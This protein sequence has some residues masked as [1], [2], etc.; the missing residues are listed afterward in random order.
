MK[1]LMLITALVIAA[2]FAYAESEM[3]R[4][5][6]ASADAS[7][8]AAAT[9]AADA[10]EVIDKGTQAVTEQQEL[11]QAETAAAAQ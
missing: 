10:V 3:A 5:V 6:A 11:S 1:G 8:E 2:P 9:T 7:A 4:D